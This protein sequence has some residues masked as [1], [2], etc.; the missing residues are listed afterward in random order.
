MNLSLFLLSLYSP[1]PSTD[2]DW[3]FFLLIL[4]LS[5]K[6]LKG[7]GTYFTQVSI[8]FQ[9]HSFYSLFCCLS[10]IPVWLCLPFFLL[11]LISTNVFLGLPQYCHSNDRKVLVIPM[12]CSLISQNCLN[13]VVF[14]CVICRL[15]L[16]NTQSPF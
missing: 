16:Q 1:L 12:V 13:Y 10:E 2:D 11:H 8:A 9:F 5:L 15:N 6:V 4:H 14:A 3:E 7:T